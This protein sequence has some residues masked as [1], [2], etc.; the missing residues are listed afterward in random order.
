MIVRDI[1]SIVIC[2]YLLLRQKYI[3]EMLLKE[4]S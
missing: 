1:C 2:Y 3:K 4:I